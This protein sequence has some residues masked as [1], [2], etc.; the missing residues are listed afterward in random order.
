MTETPSWLDSFIAVA[1]TMPTENLAVLSMALVA[2]A[3][4]WRSS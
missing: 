1:G 2:L 3:V 4:I